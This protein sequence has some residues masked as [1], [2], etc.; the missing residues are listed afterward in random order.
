[1]FYS[2]STSD[3]FVLRFRSV[4]HWTLLRRDII[5]TLVLETTAFGKSSPF[6]ASFLSFFFFLLF[7]V[8]GKERVGG[9]GFACFHI[10]WCCHTQ[11]MSIQE[12]SVHLTSH[13]VALFPPTCRGFTWYECSSHVMPDHHP[14]AVSATKL[15][16]LNV[17]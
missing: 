12:T 17:T 13:F 3:C 15:I 14:R 16:S 6:F 4:L 5:H 7:F 2:F 9:G 1:M 10:A 11:F 8:K